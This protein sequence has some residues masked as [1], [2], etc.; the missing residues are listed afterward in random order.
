MNTPKTICF[1]KVFTSII[2][3]SFFFCQDIKEQVL[4]T[5]YNGA[6]KE[7]LKVFAS[8]D[9]YVELERIVYSKYGKPTFVES[10]FDKRTVKREYHSNRK[11]KREIN[12]KDGILDGQILEYFENGQLKCSFIYDNGEIKPGTY[13]SYY[14]NGFLEDTYTLGE[15]KE[16][17]DNGNLKLKAFAI[18]TI[19]YKSSIKYNDFLKSFVDTTT[20][21][22]KYKGDYKKYFE[23]GKLKLFI[24]NINWEQEKNYDEINKIKK[25]IK[26]RTKEIQRDII[27]IVKLIVEDQLSSSELIDEFQNLSKDMLSNKLLNEINNLMDVPQDL[28]IKKI[29][30]LLDKYSF[31]VDQFKE[32][33]DVFIK[34]SNSKGIDYDIESSL[35]AISDIAEDLTER[36]LKAD[37]TRWYK[38]LINMENVR[39]FNETGNLIYDFQIYQSLYHD[40]YKAFFDNGQ[41]KIM[42]QYSK[43]LKTG[44]WLEFDDEGSVVVEENWNDGIRIE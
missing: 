8:D 30:K 12:Y 11:L 17:Y 42:G 41:K 19:T 1:L 43:G 36:L 18:D 44:L 32:Q 34:M 23:D 7:V 6:K 20:F 35:M 10:F 13:S 24:E 31:I 3:F 33:V 4:S 2:Y 14:V 27:K 28:D 16:F 37:K 22:L 39:I 5:Y 15:V 40:E 38:D 9:Y 26:N 25:Q 29:N 21:G